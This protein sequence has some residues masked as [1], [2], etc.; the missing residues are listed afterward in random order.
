MAV[1]DIEVHEVVNRDAEV[2]LRPAHPVL[3]EM[4]DLISRRGWC[5]GAYECDGR[6]C[7]LGAFYEMLEKDSTWPLDDCWEAP[8]YFA[9]HAFERAIAE[10]MPA[11]DGEYWDAADWNDMPFRTKFEVIDRLRRV[12]WLGK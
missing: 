4:A 5:Q 9:L 1:L 12:G 3:L 8:Y 11:Q 2:P 10:E 6:L 7:V